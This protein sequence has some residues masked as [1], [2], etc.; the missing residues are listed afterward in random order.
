[1]KVQEIKEKS[2]QELQNLIRES[3]EKMKKMRFALANRQLENVKDIAITKKTI[4]R[5][6]TFLKERSIKKII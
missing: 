5:A 2:D 3:K 1:M 6:K 4:A